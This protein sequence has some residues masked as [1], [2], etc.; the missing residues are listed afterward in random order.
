MFPSSVVLDKE[1]ETNATF[2]SITDSFALIKSG[3][4]VP[5]DVVSI[6]TGFSVQ[7]GITFWITGK[8]SQIFEYVILNQKVKFRN[9][10]SGKIE[11]EMMESRRR[12]PVE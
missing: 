6:N 11:F 3:S 2:G 4:I 9:T 7:V 8:L 5:L 10:R 12:K 1:L